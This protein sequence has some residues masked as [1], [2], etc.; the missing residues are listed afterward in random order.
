MLGVQFVLHG[1]KF[2]SCFLFLGGKETHVCMV[3]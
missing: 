1:D 2:P 3:R